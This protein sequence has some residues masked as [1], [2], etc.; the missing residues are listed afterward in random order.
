MP[1]LREQP[2]PRVERAARDDHDDDRH[3]DDHYDP[4]DNDPPESE[5]EAEEEAEAAALQAWPTL[6]PRQAVPA[7][8][9][10]LP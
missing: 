1:G 3:H 5:A 4:D 10:F 2:V 9:T 6:T 7:P 8:L